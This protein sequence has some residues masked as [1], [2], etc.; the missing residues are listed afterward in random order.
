[1]SL[2]VAHSIHPTVQRF[3]SAPCYSFQLQKSQAGCQEGLSSRLT[4]SDKPQEASSD[5]LPQHLHSLFTLHRDT[6]GLRPSASLKPAGSAYT[7]AGA[8]MCATRR[9]LLHRSPGAC[10]HVQL[11]ITG[12]DRAT[13]LALFSMH[14]VTHL[15]R[16]RTWTKLRSM[17]SRTMCEQGLGSE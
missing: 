1:M 6:A 14:D 5:A 13:R 10:M 12:S 2:L 17:L 16:L 15:Y 4:G 8:C 11:H 3:R 9:K 7:A